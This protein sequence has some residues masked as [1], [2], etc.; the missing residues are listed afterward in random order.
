MAYKATD[1]EIVV[2]QARYHYT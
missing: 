1:G 2:V